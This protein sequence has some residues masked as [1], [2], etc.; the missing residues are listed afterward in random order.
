MGKPKLVITVG[1]TGSGKATLIE[2]VGKYLGID[3]WEQFL[4]DDYVENDPTY[5]EKV[6]E[7]LDSL[8][9]L[10]ILNTPSD[11]LY[12]L[13]G[14][15]Y[16]S[17]RKGEGCGFA[18][19]GGCEARFDKELDE[20]IGN[21]KNIIFETTGTYFP[22]WLVEKTDGKYDIIL[23]Y[24]LV[25]LCSLFQRNRNRA[26]VQSE[27]FIKD[28]EK[29]PAPRL[30]NVSADG[31]YP[32]NVEQTRNIFFEI[33]ANDCL[34]ARGKTNVDY[35]SKYNIDHILLFN[36]NER[37]MKLIADMTK[38]RPLKKKQLLKIFEEFMNTSVSCEQP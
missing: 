35:C 18:G 22:K 26:F 8:S 6:L 15:A 27:Q 38:Y 34:G 17:V 14:N 25:N 12:Q 36:N 4:I 21:G 20:A 9:G 16:F 24:T 37:P 32:K 1:P 23:A 13:F 5:K 11:D 2:E 19:K 3:D 28:P 29:Y 30:P 33:I 7:I 31:P 10:N